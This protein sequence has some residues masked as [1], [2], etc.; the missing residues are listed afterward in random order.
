MDERERR[1]RRRMDDWVG[2]TGRREFFFNGSGREEQKEGG[3]SRLWT[4]QLD[5][6]LGGGIATTAASREGGTC[7]SWMQ[8]TRV[9]SMRAEREATDANAHT[10]S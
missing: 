2:G 9:A 8:E 1:R 7:V 5:A 4:L 3:G 6:L 10:H